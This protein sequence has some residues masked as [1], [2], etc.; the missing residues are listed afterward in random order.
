MGS[1]C[2]AGPGPRSGVV[3]LSTL[4][5]AVPGSAARPRRESPRCL[6]S[7]QCSS[8][9]RVSGSRAFVPF[10][11]SLPCVFRGRLQGPSLSSPCSLPIDVCVP[12]L[13]PPPGAL[14]SPLSVGRQEQGGLGFSVQADARRRGRA[15]LPGP[16]G[17]CAGPG[18]CRLR[19]IALCCS[20]AAP[21]RRPLQPRPLSCLPLAAA[22]PTVRA[23]QDP[24]RQPPP[25][26]GAA[27]GGGWAWQPAERV[28]SGLRAAGL[29]GGGREWDPRTPPSA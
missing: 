21:A 23:M 16:A 29:S 6:A 10:L 8:R 11:R 19:G 18:G 2:L 5:S 22:A 1:R 24:V 15:G 20:T 25:W 28:P 4:R 7:P 26:S 17:L 13:L 14:A 12:V 9:P 3:G 27:Q